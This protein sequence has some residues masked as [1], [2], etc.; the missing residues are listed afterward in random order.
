MIEI[1]I[2]EDMLIWSDKLGNDEI[3]TIREV[4][5]RLKGELK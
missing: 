2:L 4:I 1:K 5:A 3:M